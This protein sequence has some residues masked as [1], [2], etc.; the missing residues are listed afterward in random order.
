[1]LILEKDD[2]RVVFHHFPLQGHNWARLAAEGAACAQ[3]QS[4]DAFWRV[5][6]QLFNSQKILTSENLTKKLAEFAADDNRLDLKAYQSCLDNE[7]SLGRVLQD[8]NLGSAYGVTGTPTIFINGRRVPAVKDTGELLE[9]IRQAKAEARPAQ[10]SKRPSNA[11][12]S[13]KKGN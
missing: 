7:L 2:V 8:I 13:T 4:G 6:Q 12:E 3:L 10:A 11:S 1:M 9:L 5:Y